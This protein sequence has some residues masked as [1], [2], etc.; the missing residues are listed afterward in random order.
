[1]GLLEDSSAGAATQLSND[2]SRVAGLEPVGKVLSAVSAL[3]DS[4]VSTNQSSTKA[5][6][7]R[8]SSL[9]H[10]SAIDRDMMEWSP[11]GDVK[12]VRYEDE[13]GLGGCRIQ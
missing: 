3:V 9:M 10:L 11:R 1:M 5:A 13:K 12:G 6:K 7:S 8:R 4:K 2:Q